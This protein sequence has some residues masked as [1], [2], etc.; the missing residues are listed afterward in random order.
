MIAVR[1]ERPEEGPAIGRVLRAAFGGEGE[2][3]LVEALRA[4]P[5]F[6]PDLSLVAV[7]DEEVV[8]H[9]LFSRVKVIESARARPALA[10]APL[11]VRPDRQGRGI[12]SALVREG[13]EAARGSGHLAVIV[14]G[15]PAY[16]PRFGFVPAVPLGIRPPFA[17]SPE[18]FQVLGLRPGALEGLRGLVEYPPPFAEL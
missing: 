4:H 13:L 2:A 6:L 9:V 18:A 3:R 10:L 8:G 12:G 17:A 1:R 11:A 16:Y 5:A 7:E 15:H 14:L